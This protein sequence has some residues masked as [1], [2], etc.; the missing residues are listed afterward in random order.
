MRAGVS[1]PL[2]ARNDDN[3]AVWDRLNRERINID[4]DACYSSV[5]DEHWMTAL[6]HPKPVPAR[7]C[8][9]LPGRSFDAQLYGPE[10]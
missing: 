9:E 4:L 10:A 5:F 7:S 3:A 6:R 8:D 1:F 2:L